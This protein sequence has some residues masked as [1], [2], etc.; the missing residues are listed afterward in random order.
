ME[1][2][3]TR[4]A[5]VMWEYRIGHSTLIL[6]S[7]FGTPRSPRI[8]V[9][10]TDVRALKVPHYLPSLTVRDPY[11]HELAAL[12][13][14]ADALYPGPVTGEEHKLFV[15]DGGDRVAWVVALWMSIA[16]DLED[17]HLSRSRI[18]IDRA[19]PPDG[20]FVDSYSVRRMGDTGLV[21]PYA[22]LAAKHGFLRANFRLSTTEEG[23]RAQPISGDYGYRPNW[24]IGTPDPQQVGGAPL[25]T[26]DEGIP[27]GGTASVT[28][29]PVW[30][31]FWAGVEPGTKLFAF[32]GPKLVGT[33]VVT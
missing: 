24:S 28:L 19:W 32:E 10:F 9:E 22:H 25:I 7:G 21:T 13:A 27:L 12:G 4:R 30:A 14:E 15:L 6:S 18:G 20:L 2:F 16:E 26:D 11:D 5:F 29:S 8:H 31:E 23:G 1:F 33:A 17:V 3:R